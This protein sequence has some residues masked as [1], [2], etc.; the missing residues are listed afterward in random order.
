MASS[1][2]LH[3]TIGSALS[4]RVRQRLTQSRLVH[5]W[6]QPV[7]APVLWIGQLSRSGGTMLLRLLDGHPQIHA[8][9]KAFS[10]GAAAAWP[11]ADRLEFDTVRRKLDMS[12]ENAAGLT[13]KSSNSDQRSIPIYFDGLWYREMCRHPKRLPNLRPAGNPARDQ[14]AVIFT[15]F[16]NAWRNYQNLY[17]DKRYVV[18]H[19]LLRPGVP[20]KQSF[21]NFRAIYPDGNWLFMVRPVNGWVSSMTQLRNAPANYTIEDGLDLYA[22]VYNDAADL[23]GEAGF[24]P[25]HFPDFVRGGE[26]AVFALADTLGLAPDPSLLTTSTNGI[27]VSQNSSHTIQAKSTIDASRADAAAPLDPALARSAGYQKCLEA[28]ERCVTA[29]HQ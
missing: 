3:M 15:A 12:R 2:P 20:L 8:V 18:G 25:L 29:L 26:A 4:N 27:P 28:Y 1:S 7:E 5:E 19:S 24:I 16:F 17:G 11:T 21:E 9:P 14:L 23:V 22:D 13:K 6:I 10:F